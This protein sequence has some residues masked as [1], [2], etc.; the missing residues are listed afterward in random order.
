MAI[1]VSHTFSSELVLHTEAKKKKNN[2]NKAI[3]IKIY[4]NKIKERDVAPW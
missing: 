1:T 4:I 2:K 3:I